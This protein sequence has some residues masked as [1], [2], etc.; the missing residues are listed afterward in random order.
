MYHSTLFIQSNIM[1]IA[2]GGQREREE[3]ERNKVKMRYCIRKYIWLT[4]VPNAY[5]KYKVGFVCRVSC[6]KKFPPRE[7][8]RVFVWSVDRT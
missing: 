4:Y 5:P 8:F 2:D 7:R 1:E 3:G 6:F